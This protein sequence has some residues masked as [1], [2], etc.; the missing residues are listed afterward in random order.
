VAEIVGTGGSEG[1][2]EPEPIDPLEDTF[3]LVRRA[4]AG[5]RKA[6]EQLFAR[7][8]PRVLTIVIA[9]L[10]PQ[11]SKRE[12]AEDLA[13]D[14]LLHA[15]RAF[16][17][18][19]LRPD[20]HLI[21]W[22]ATIV[23]N[24]IRDV[25]RRAQVRGIERHDGD[26]AELSTYIR[27]G[28]DEGTLLA[29]SAGGGVQPLSEIIRSESAQRVRQVLAELDERERELIVRWTMQGCSWAEI[30]EDLGFPTPDAARMAFH[31]AKLELGR[32]LRDLE[33][34]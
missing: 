27:Q 34:S 30:A 29:E 5:E 26:L 13:Q 21:G 2:G 23:E 20:A 7:Y 4:Q 12:D 6:Y 28:L 9:R 24:R 16:N 8:Y 33:G 14:A 3:A 25:W 15:L 18:F 1:R 17:R 19:E 32:R 31:R 11:L 10:G 22:F